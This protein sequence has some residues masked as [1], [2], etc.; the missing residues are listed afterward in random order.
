MVS[1]KECLGLWADREGI[2]KPNPFKGLGHYLE[3]GSVRSWP[4]SVTPN[5]ELN[6]L[7][8]SA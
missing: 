7:S 5:T 2:S 8:I 4:I 3:K 6:L 1:G